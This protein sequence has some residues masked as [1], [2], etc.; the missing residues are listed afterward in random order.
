MQSVVTQLK[1]ITPGYLPANLFYEVSRLAVV[2][3]VEVVPLRTVKGACEVLLTQRLAND[4]HWPNLWHNPGSIMRPNDQVGSFDSAITRICSDELGMGDWPT[5]I[6]VGT[7]FWQGARGSIVSLVHT[8][9]ISGMDSPAVGTF[10]P[11]ANLPAEFIP[12]MEPIIVM[13]VMHYQ[14]NTSA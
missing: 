5:P 9:D 3:A 7:H 13:A 11:V 12:G 10:F 1:S 8:L 6:F 14:K 4:P 2:C